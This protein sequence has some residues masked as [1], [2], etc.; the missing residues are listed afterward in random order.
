[1]KMLATRPDT[2][3]PTPSTSD[4]YPAIAVYSMKNTVVKQKLTSVQRTKLRVNSGSIQVFSRLPT[5]G[6]L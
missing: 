3:L 4:E 6:H 2:V 5:S 1:M